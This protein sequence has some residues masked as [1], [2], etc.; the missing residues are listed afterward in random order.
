MSNNYNEKSRADRVMLI[1]TVISLVLVAVLSVGLLC[2]R[3][4]SCRGK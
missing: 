1:V 4:R 3:A 2:V